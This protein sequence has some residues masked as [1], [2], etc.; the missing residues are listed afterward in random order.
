[1]SAPAPRENARAAG[2]QGERRARGLL[3]LGAAV[4]L[5]LAAASLLST[6][7]GNGGLPD[8]VVARVNNATVRAEEYQRLVAA[9]ASDR[10]NPLS[11]AD[12]LHVLD[13]LIEEELLVQHAVDLGL[14]HTDRRVR[15]D[16]VSA[17]L[18]SL[19][20]AAD[21]YEPEPDEVEE[22]YAE[23][24]D[25]F[26]T[27]GR[28]WVRELYIARDGEGM[29]LEKASQASARLRGGEALESVREA[30][31][32]QPVAPLP[33]APLPPAKLREYLGPT[34]LS[35]ALQLE[36][37]QVSEPVPTPQGYLVLVMVE[38]SEN[39]ARELEAVEVQVRAEMRRRAGDRL[40][41]ERLDALRARADVSTV[42]ELP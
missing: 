11:D 22:F 26:A 21:G 7:A 8:G 3:A 5:A 42:A 9:L 6:P 13:R 4:G 41:R 16:L 38:R 18:G 12:R 39:R 2:P 29:D 14:L 10:R 15:A 34:A 1:M 40:L 31:A 20:A 17:V 33:A 36:P 30:L 28:L 32:D 27:P 25:Y 24:R 35:V 19:S 37:G 23:N